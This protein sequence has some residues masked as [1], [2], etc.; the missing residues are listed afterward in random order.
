MLSESRSACVERRLFSH[1]VGK[2]FA[3]TASTTAAVVG[4]TPRRDIL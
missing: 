4:R 1:V 2:M 3:T